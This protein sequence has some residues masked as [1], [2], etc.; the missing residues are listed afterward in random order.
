[1]WMKG[2]E[3]VGARNWHEEARDRKEWRTE[4]VATV[5]SGLRRLKR[6]IMMK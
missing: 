6:M 4:L 1:M 5:Y 3:E 2:P